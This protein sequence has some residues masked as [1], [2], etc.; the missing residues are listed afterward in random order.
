[1]TPARREAAIFAVAAAVS[2]ACVA[3]LAV[4]IQRLPAETFE[5]ELRGELH[6]LAAPA[7]LA[8]V[9]VL[10]FLVVVAA[11]SLADLPALA[12][13]ASVLLRLAFL[14]AL[15]LALARP[16][17]VAD[18]TRVGVVALLDVSDSMSPEAVE[19]ARGSIAELRRAAGDADF[20]LVT[21]ARTA[22]RVP[23]P[24]GAPIPEVPT[25]RHDPASA[26]PDQPGRDGAGSD[27]EGALDLAGSL[28]QPG[29][30]RRLVVLSD[31]VETA[32]DAARAA[33]RTRRF[34]A[35]LSVIPARRPPPPEVSV[36]S[37]AAPSSVSIGEPFDLRAEVRAT[38]PTRARLRLLQGDATNALDGQ[39]EVELPAGTTSVT[40]RSVVRVAG[41]LTYTLLADAGAADTF[42]ANDRAVTAIDVPG[43]PT[44]LA[45]DPRP[46]DLSA[47]ARALGAQELDVELRSPT[48][49][50]GSLEELER[51]DFVIVSDTPV[52]ALP[53]T[54]QP[55]LERYVRDLGGA[56]LFSGGPQGFGLGGW[57]RQP[58]ERILP[59]R[60]DAERRREIPTVAMM[61]VLDRSGSMTGLPLEM[62]KTAAR[63]TV[64]TLEAD[65]LV[66]VI[67]FDSTPIRYVRLQPAR[68]RA[69]I[70]ADIARVLPGGGTEFFSALDAAYQDLRVTPARR[71]HVILL[72][73]GRAEAPGL[74]DL[75]QAM[76]AESITVTTVGLGDGADGDLLRALAEA[77]GGRY[78]AAPDPRSLPQIFTRETELVARKAAVEDWFPMT[79]TAKAEFLRGV[80]VEAAPLL[81]G[82]VATQ[83]RESP[84]SGVLSTD[85]GE[86]LLARLRVGLGWTLAWT[87]D[88]KAGWAVDL[89]RWPAFPRLFGQLVREH[90]RRQRRTELPLTAEVVGERVHVVVD[91]FTSDERFDNGLESTVTLSAPGAAGPR[92]ELALARTAPGR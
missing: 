25:L 26:P 44:V 45:V 47:L 3:S 60:M 17:R 73:D 79:V 62:A 48:A 29:T 36:L 8:V 87:S 20:S 46:E 65:D 68:Y 35:R 9:G 85:E 75:T 84:A 40:F 52:D 34:G 24:P 63:A 12:R 92:Q 53:G 4:A 31:G 86:P 83:L 32:G 64:E 69:R 43:R 56:L 23:L 5:A 76:L 89:L 66:G 57:S 1:M 67:A 13:A 14:S 42:H 70:A 30:V 21:F 11:R 74:R 81:R 18:S 91:A 33:E 7:Y 50:P 28:F 39:R 61:L 59:V 10:P 72:T 19:D 90:L 82:Y 55:L 58:L 49:F 2:A 51:F 6:R 41:K 22:R 16:S 80:A 78:H 77:G 38:R 37:L 15:G 27:L 71:K 88:L 54:A